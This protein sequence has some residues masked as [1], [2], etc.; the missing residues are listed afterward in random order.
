M[1]KDLLYIKV[2]NCE[3]YKNKIIKVNHYLYDKNFNRI[4]KLVID[5]DLMD[6]AK[7][8]YIK[9]L[10]GHYLRLE[11]IRLLVGYE[12]RFLKIKRLYLNE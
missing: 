12:L 6:I 3:I 1:F 11:N 4:N 7:T 9:T 5:S 8:S 10:H 2:I